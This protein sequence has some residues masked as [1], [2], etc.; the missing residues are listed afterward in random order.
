MD[1]DVAYDTT[2][3]VKTSIWGVVVTLFQALALVVIVVFVFLQDWR[4]TIIPAIAIPVSLIGTFAALGALGFSINT[5]SLFGLILAIGVVVDDAIVVVENVQRHMTDGLPPKEAT[6]KAMEEVTGPVVA[7]TLVLLAVF[8]PIV[9]TPGLTGR[10]FVQFAVTIAVS[11]SISSIVALTLS[12]ALCATLLKPASQVSWGP[13]AWFERTLDVTRTGYVA[14]VRRLVRVSAIALVGFAAAAVGTGAISRILPTGFIPSEDRGAFFV[15]IRLPDGASLER[16]TGVI[17]R[18]ETMIMENEGV[19]DVLTVGGY[20]LL[21]GA[22]SSNAGFVVATLDP[23]DERGELGLSL[24][25]ILTRLV[26]QLQAVSEATI[27]PFNPPPI[28]GLGTTGGFQ[29]VLQDTEGRSP[30]VLA[31]AVNGMIISANGNPDLTRVFSTYRANIPQYF[32]DLDRERA[33]SRGVAI[34]DVF[35]VLSANFGSYYVNDFNKF[36]RLYRVYI[37]AEGDRRIRPDQIGDLFVRNNVGDMV[38]MRALVKIE[39]VLG[40]ETIERYNLF[41]AA[42]LNGDPAPGRSSG[43]ALAAMEETAR[44]TMP[45]GF[46]F[47][48]TGMSLEEIK[49]GAAGSSVLLLSVIFAYLFLVAQ[50][51]SWTTPLAVMLSVIFAV[52][53]AFALLVVVGIPLNSYAQIG[54]V[55]LIGLAAKNAIL[56]VEFAKNLHESG[57]SIAAA[58][59]EAASLRFRAVLMTAFSFILGVLPL[60]FASGAG[61]ASQKSVGMTVFGGMSAATVLGV[62]FIPALFA[63]FVGMAE[64]ISG[65]RPAPADAPDAA[66]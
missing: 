61:A 26:P 18:V 23:W 4:S 21:S 36:G 28:P 27:L 20:S 60:V 40:P 9:F 44:T 31:S 19:A 35:Q 24:E 14:I 49:A 2:E 42:T 10:L 22:V 15:D 3:Y 58:A 38:P 46:A 63:V 13:L 16:T 51:E 52:L 8:V 65:V 12:P 47:E 43:Q 11:V 5:V 37:Q 32:V 55:L 66:E 29:F 1:Y 62:I 45:S 41:R 50:Y 64:R 57:K 17:E 39:P 33:K 25:S 59:E 7:T 34:S 30:T 48:W 53:G 56:I 6:R 54:L